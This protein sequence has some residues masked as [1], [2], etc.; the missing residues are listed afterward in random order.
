LPDVNIPRRGDI[1]V[2]RDNSAIRCRIVGRSDDQVVI[3][4]VGESSFL[5]DRPKTFGLATFMRN[6]TLVIRPKES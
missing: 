6:F 4:A 1:W 2:N 5:G 3:E